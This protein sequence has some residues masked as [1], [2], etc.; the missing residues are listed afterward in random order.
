MSKKELAKKRERE[1][2]EKELE[3]QGF[4]KRDDGDQPNKKASAMVKKNKN[5]K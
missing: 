4:Y 3:E 5:K 1:A 2:K